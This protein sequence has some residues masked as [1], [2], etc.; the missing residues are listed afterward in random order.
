MSAT[1]AVSREQAEHILAT[2]QTAGANAEII[3]N[4]ELL[5]RR[6]RSRCKGAANL[7]QLVDALRVL[8]FPK[9]AWCSTCPLLAAWIT[10]PAPSMR[11]LLGDLPAIGSVC[12]GGRYDDLA[13]LYTKQHL[14]GVGA[15]LGLDR[16]MAAM[17]VR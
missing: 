14:P 4:I 12:S 11:T 17:E 5:P 16:L 10:T 1:D 15:S 8:A 7:R 13:G 3:N 6:Q 9:I 2:V